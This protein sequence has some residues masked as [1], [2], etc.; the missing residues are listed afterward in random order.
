MEYLADE[1]AGPETIAGEALTS[2][3]AASRA[4]IAQRIAQRIAEASLTVVVS[5]IPAEL[6][7]VL[8]R[9]AAAV[10]VEEV[11]EAGRRWVNALQSKEYKRTI[12][13]LN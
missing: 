13:F 3:F 8:V 6:G 1:I 11:I 4:R 9:V 2:I 10:V 7:P 5:A 12:C